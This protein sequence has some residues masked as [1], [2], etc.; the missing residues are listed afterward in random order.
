MTAAAQAPGATPIVL[1]RQECLALLAG[2]VIGRVVVPM[3]ATGRPVVRPVNYAF[4]TVSQS[5]VFRSAPGGKLH[6]LLLAA[7]ACFEVDAFDPGN[8][9][10]WSV[11]IQGVTEPV[12]DAMEVRRLEGLT[13]HSWVTGAGGQLMR[14]RARTI[15]GRRIE[16]GSPE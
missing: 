16:A 5:V 7:Q 8:R 3:G 12:T 9:T 10:G 13:L 1:T 15:S 4:D 14:I 6:A 2:A 11:I